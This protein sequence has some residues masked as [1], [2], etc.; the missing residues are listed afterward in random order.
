MKMKAR[1]RIGAYFG[2]TGM[3]VLIAVLIAV[4]DR[5]IAIGPWVL[6]ILLAAMGA[7]LLYYLHK[8]YV[9][10]RLD[11]MQLRGRQ[12][13]LA[14]QEQKIL[15]M[16]TDRRIG[17]SQATLDLYLRR[18]RIYPDKGYMPALV[19]DLMQGLPGP[20]DFLLLPQPNRTGG[21]PRADDRDD[22][23]T[24]VAQ[25]LPVNVRYAD[26]AHLIPPG[27]GLLGVAAEGVAT[28]Q[29]EQFMT[30]LV[31]GGSNSGKSNTLAIKIE[32]AIANGR[33]VRFLVVDWHFQKPDSLY[34]KI[35]SYEHLFLRPV[36]TD[37]EG[38]LQALEWFYSEFNRRRAEG[39]TDQDYD[40]V[41]IVEE[42][43]GIMDDAEDEAIPKL[44]KR[45]AKKCGR[46]ARGYGMYG[47]FIAQQL[48]GIAWLRNV[49]HTVIGHKAT[50]LNEALVVCNEHKDEARDMEN[51]PTGRV[52]VYGQNFQGI[53]V[54]QMPTFTPRV[55]LVDGS[56]TVAPK[57]YTPEMEALQPPRDAFPN[58][59]TQDFPNSSANFPETQ[60][61]AALE[62]GGN[63]TETVAQ[64]SAFELKKFLAET[65]KRRAE[66]VPLN[67]ILREQ[68]L[69]T[70]GRTH[71]EIQEILNEMDAQ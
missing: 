15:G 65:R 37:E 22:P 39:I 32:E 17:M 16:E 67:T 44:L 64:L 40:V 53:R 55:G 58:S 13:E 2:L 12:L 1:N 18:T 45:V 25:A 29:F 54:L 47:W 68:G 9:G 28:C 35:Q 50:R 71:Q 6:D 33:N 41:L 11:H 21:K 59:T 4:R 56:I 49:V 23:P 3:T 19:N 62:K 38:T 42:V 66:G 51:W 24:S 60:R 36:I 63:Q 10:F 46:E 30:M 20:T 57:P 43:P 5:L 7:V 69:P 27:H 8:L 61:E 34:R 52:I 48:I 31:S 26:I 14:E 70:G